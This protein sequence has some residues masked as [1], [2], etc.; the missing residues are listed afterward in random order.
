MIFPVLFFLLCFLLS[1][2]YTFYWMFV[3]IHSDML[4]FVIHC[5]SVY[6]VAPWLSPRPTSSTLITSLAKSCFLGSTFSLNPTEFTLAPLWP[7][8]TSSVIGFS[9]QATTSRY[10]HK[11]CLSSLLCAM[12]SW[13]KTDLVL[14]IICISDTA[15]ACPLHP[16]CRD[17]MQR[18]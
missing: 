7:A 17:C 8:L 10:T 12:F 9:A 15:H 14:N 11:H 5:A 18:C 3:Y 4:M 13:N 16:F 2:L 1:C 6:C